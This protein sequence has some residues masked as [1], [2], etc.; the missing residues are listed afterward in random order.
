[1]ETET[2][3]SASWLARRLRDIWRMAMPLWLFRDA[4]R[5]TL[6]QRVANYHYNRSLRSRLPF[7][8]A[9][10]IVIALCLMQ[11][12]RVLSELMAIT[13]VQTSPHIYATVFCMS[14]GIGFAF[15]CVVLAVLLAS[16]LHF[17]YV[18]H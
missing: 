1:M 3:K 16:Y 14:A 13:H 17:S 2:G 7:Y 10:W 4:G 15:A 5:G 9:T 6:E 18:Q 11:L 8:M 12:M